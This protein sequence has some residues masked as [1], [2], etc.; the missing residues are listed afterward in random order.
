MN[1]GAEI[2][3]GGGDMSAFV[4]PLIAIVECG[5]HLNN[6]KKKK[7]NNVLRPKLHQLL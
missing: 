3:H 7:E 4:F 6:G 2:H 5:C 1:F